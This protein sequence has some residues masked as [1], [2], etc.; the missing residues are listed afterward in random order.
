MR[1]T[2]PGAF[3]KAT[4]IGGLPVP[5]AA[6]ALPSVRSCFPDLDSW[7]FNRLRLISFRLA[8]TR[9]QARL[10]AEHH[11]QPEGTELIPNLLMMAMHLCGITKNLNIGCGFNVVPMW[12]Q[13][14][15]AEDYAMV[16][17]LTGGRVIFGVGRSYHTREVETFDAPLIDQNANREMFEEG[18]RGPVQGVRAQ[19]V[20]AQG[21]VLD[22][23]AGGAVSRLHLE[24]DRLVPAPE[25]LPVECWPPIQ[26]GSERAS[27]SSTSRPPASRRSA[28]PPRITKRT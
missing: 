4:D 1:N 13:L 28:R 19:A 27:T 18:G 9:A 11:F 22:D 15:L 17:I 10:M 26:S 12:H 16:D 21:Q 8:R 25:R 5:V 3:A 7:N 23:P 2:H 14:R 24:G 6:S 20:L